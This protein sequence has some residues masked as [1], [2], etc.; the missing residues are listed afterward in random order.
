MTHHLR[1]L[2]RAEAMS[3]LR[4]ALS[5][6]AEGRGAL[7]LV[8]GQAGVGKT[9]LLAA[10]SR[11]ATRRGFRILSGRGKEREREVPMI[12][13][14]DLFR[15]FMADLDPDERSSLLRGSAAL[16]EP[17]F[18]TH[19]APPQEAAALFE[20]L[21]WLTSNLA[22][23]SPVAILI[24]DG[25]WA[26]ALSVR[27]LAYL[28]ARLEEL[29]VAVM[30]A[31]R[32]YEPELMASVNELRQHPACRRVQLGPLS[33]PGSG[34]LVRTVFPESTERFCGACFEATGGNPFYLRA[35]LAELEGVIGRGT[36]DDVSQVRAQGPNT[37]AQSVRVRLATVDD[38]AVRLAQSVAVLDE[39]A[40]LE[41]AARLAG[42]DVEQATEWAASL[43][44]AG[45]LVPSE[46]LSFVH[47]I[48]RT[49]TYKDIPPPDRV[50]AHEAAVRVMLAL[51][52]PPEKI[53]PHLL[54]AGGIEGVETDGIL[55]A[56]AARAKSR[57]APQIAIDYLQRVLAGSLAVE[58]RV[59]VLVEL[60]EAEA[61]SGSLRAVTRSAEAANLCS[62]PEQRAGARL[63]IARALISANLRREAAGVVA[64]GFEELGEGHHELRRELEATYVFAGLLDPDLHEAA[65]RRIEG[66][67]VSAT[68]AT[69][70]VERAVMA[71]KALYLSASGEDREQ[72]VA[73]ANLAYGAG[74]LI[75]EEGG[76]G[77]TASI[78]CGV[79]LVADQLHS[80]IRVCDSL[81]AEARARGSVSGFA[82][83]SFNRTHPLRLV[84]RIPDAIADA[85]QA[86]DARRFGWR[87][88]VVP[89]QAQLAHALMDSGDISRA[90]EVL[91]SLDDADHR[92]SVEFG[93]FLEARGRWHLLFD[94]YEDA[95]A[96]LHEARLRFED[97]SFLNL[98]TLSVWRQYFVPAALSTGDLDAAA[99]V[100][101]EQLAR[102]K[103]WGA[104]RG[105]SVAF[106]TSATVAD[107]SAAA[108][109]MLRQAEKHARESEATVEHAHALV[110]LGRALGAAGAGAE[111][112]EWLR[113]GIDTA[114]RQG[115]LLLAAQGLKLISEAGGRPRR[116][117]LTGIEALTPS[118]R[119]IADMVASGS[120]NRE[121]A[122]ALFVTVKNVESHL[123]RVFRKLSISR[124][125]QLAEALRAELEP[126]PGEDQ[127]TGNIDA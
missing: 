23:R 45:I 67:L 58:E 87:L 112:R 34:E 91:T 77:M 28:A 27:F 61:M 118:E 12:V 8:E 1:L 59:E 55:R 50:A 5:S 97:N 53:A 92:A 37:V 42:V 124:R 36:D 54:L 40:E 94:R 120:S 26:D 99:L 85:Q 104:P 115:A 107:E 83:A 60:G 108:V 105:L 62:D 43:A 57:G 68:D 63:R 101:E 9:A 64:P 127:M 16:A 30:V 3:L 119:R 46:P 39:N 44:A 31:T 95:Y 22:E 52:A 82:T 4:A 7:R 100:A 106:R 33:R 74:A 24:D 72:A 6:A 121:A 13:V 48:V 35:L 18:Q 88:F 80:G 32:T 2:E 81:I 93:F 103:R 114:R 25:R 111:A 41:V 125:S 110:A 17:L 65:R 69:L 123:V 66:V 84:G 20:G 75:K 10:L 109:A 38:G 29:P 89:A 117:A 76:E 96:D 73:L 70:G 14:E 90:G 98:P 78:L 21:F 51:D 47:P 11:E 49:S 113:G 56:A 86:I 19:P 79:F 116:L 15:C 122:E 102:A 71:H 126:P